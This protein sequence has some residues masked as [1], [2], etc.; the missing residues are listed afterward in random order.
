MDTITDF[1]HATDKI[2]LSQGIFARL[3]RGGLKAANF[4]ANASGVALNA[5]H[6]IIYN[7]RT[8][9]LLYDRDG[10]GG[11]AAVRFATLQNKADLTA[12]DFFVSQ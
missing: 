8:G 11:A 9:A 7:T 5:N 4:T 2:R 1:R 12:S 10:K 6:R 3:A